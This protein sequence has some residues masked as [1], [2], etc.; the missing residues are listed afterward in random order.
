MEATILSYEFANK[1]DFDVSL[2]FAKAAIEDKVDMTSPTHMDG[3]LILDTTCFYPQGGGQPTDEGMIK[4]GNDPDCSFV[5]KKV[6]IN[7]FSQVIHSG[8]GNLPFWST[9]LSASQ[10][11]ASATEPS[12]EPSTEPAVKKGEVCHRTVPV[13]LQVNEKLRMLYMRLHSTGHALDAAMRNVGIESSRL[14]GTKGYH[15]LDGPY[16]EYQLQPYQSELTVEELSTLPQLLTTE[17]RRLVGLNILTQ[18]DDMSRESVLEWCK[19]DVQGIDLS[20]YP[21]IVRMVKI[22]G[23]YIPC[24]GTHIRSSKEIGEEVLVTRLKKKKTAYKVSYTL[25]GI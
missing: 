11:T 25:A 23:M 5:V 3:F 20:A 2:S 18:T 19:E 24:G 10:A 6:T 7:E 14:L 1:D 16:V 12:P 22:C 4:L 15:F 21:D 13:Y 9:L 8:H 17:L